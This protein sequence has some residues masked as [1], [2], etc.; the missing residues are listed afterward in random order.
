MGLLDELVSE[1]THSG[2]HGQQDSSSSRPPPV[3]PP[4]IA[5]WDSRDN[6]WLF[7]NQQTGERTFT[8]PDPGYA[9]QQDIYGGNQGAYNQNSYNPTQGNDQHMSSGNGWKYAAAGAAGLAGGAFAVYEGHE[10]REDWDE[11][12]WKL[13]NDK[14]R[15]E[16][17]I[18]NAPYNAANWTGEQV[19]R[20][21]RLDDRVDQKVDNAIDD[22]ENAPENIANWTGYKVQEVEDIPQNIENR[23]DNGVDR[24]ENRFDNVIDRIE[25]FGDNVQDSYNE[26]RDERRYDDD[27]DY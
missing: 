23:W 22:V 20:L 9:Q 25:N 10:I 17:G 1:F 12:K 5:E 26:G 14:E 8:Y 21:E 15:L 27:D 4:W 3:S 16:N 6:R 18:E 2:S 13:H 7:V 11:E 19:D 24:V